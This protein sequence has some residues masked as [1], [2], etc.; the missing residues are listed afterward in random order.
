MRASSIPEA[1]AGFPKVSNNGKTYDFTIN[2]RVHEVLERPARDGGVASRPS[3]T[4]IADPKM[5]SPSGAF[6]SDIV[7]AAK[8][9]VS[10]VRVKGNHLIITLTHAAPDLLAR[11]A[12]P[13]FCALPA[14]TGARPERRQHAA[15]GAARTTSR[16]GSRTGRSCSSATRTTRASG[17]TTR[18]RS[19]TRSATR[20]TRRTCAFS[21]ARPT[22]RPA[23]SRRR[24]TP[25]RL[26]STASTRASSG[27]SR[28]SRRRTSRSTRRGASSRTTCRCGRPSTRRSTGARCWRRAAT[29]PASGPTRSCLR[30]WPA[31]VTPICIRSSSRT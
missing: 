29:W 28:C 9:P 15:V 22:T 6:M 13:F 14:N 10:G 1:A 4:G 27:S 7:G 24:R 2:D 23:A 30:A 11:L 18:R 8:S 31:S 5:Q 19:S 25:R 26:R 12:M 17:R 21:R 16:T 3:S 20:S